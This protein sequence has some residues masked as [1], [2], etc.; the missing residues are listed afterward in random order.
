MRQANPGRWGGVILAIFLVALA[1]AC[2]SSGVAVTGRGQVMNLD[3]NV[4]TDLSEGETKEMTVSVSNRGVNRLDDV[5]FEVEMPNE[6]IVLSQV[7]S[8]G[9][10]MTERFS[11]IGTKIF[12]YR[13]GNIEVATSSQVK[14]H[15][16]AAFA[17]LDRTGDIKV[18][19][20]SEDLPG[21]RLVETKFVKLRA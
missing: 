5:I 17:S 13:A 21:D 12:Q 3:I 19:A 18:T 4:P 16:R 9:V 2:K 11:S 20:W 7:P 8:R 1:G 15:V 10:Q 14:F 6:L